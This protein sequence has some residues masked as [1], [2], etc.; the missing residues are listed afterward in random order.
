MK[1]LQLFS[2]AAIGVVMA[3]TALAD[4]AVEA[5]IEARQSHMH[6]NAFNVGVLAAMAK[7]TV[8]YDSAVASAAAANLVALTSMDESRYWIEGSDNM[9]AEKTRALPA[10][11]D[12]EPDFLTKIAAM[13]AAAVTMQGAAG[14]DLAALQAALGAVGGACGACHK[15]YRAPE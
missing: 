5:A 6:L 1:M 8:S 15:M 7:G 4:A 12:N 3:G 10:I 9:S 14:T 11:W 13:N 2:V